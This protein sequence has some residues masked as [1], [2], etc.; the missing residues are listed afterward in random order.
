MA[1]LEQRER[2]ISMHEKMKNDYV[3]FKPP[4]SSERERQRERKRETEENLVGGQVEQISCRFSKQSHSAGNQTQWSYS[5]KS[6]V[7]QTG[8]LIK[9]ATEQSSS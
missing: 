7:R 8:Q 2:K 1:N 4:L 3:H 9:A 5:T 6:L